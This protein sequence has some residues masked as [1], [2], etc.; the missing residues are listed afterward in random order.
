MA[1]CQKHGPPCAS[2]P[3]CDCGRPTPPP[4]PAAQG[5][6]R[7]HILT[8]VGDCVSWCP[9]CRTM[10]RECGQQP[11]CACKPHPSP[12]PPAP[13]VREGLDLARRFH[14]AYERLAPSFGYETRKDTREF[15]PTTPNGRL[16]VAVCSELLAALR[17]PVSPAPSEVACPDCHGQ[18]GLPVQVSETEQDLMPCE[19]CDTRGYIDADRVEGIRRSEVGKMEALAHANAEIERLRAV[20]PAPPP[21]D[22]CGGTGEDVDD[23]SNVGAGITS[24]PCSFCNGTG[25]RTP[26]VSPAPHAREALECRKCGGYLCCAACGEMFKD[27]PDEKE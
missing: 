23:M 24:G 15:D 2:F 20:S 11:P 3:A 27:T 9:A 5:Q 14:E 16:M 19:L 6:E 8:D 22:R 21:C 25:D 18:G 12:V 26:T 1:N 13:D 4:A 17:A 7:K 10:C